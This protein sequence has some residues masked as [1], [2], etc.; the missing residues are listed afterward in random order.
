[1]IGPKNNDA[2]IHHQL[3][4]ISPTSLS[5]SNTVNSVPLPHPIFVELFAIVIVLLVLH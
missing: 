1:M 3:I 4:C 5:T 2:T